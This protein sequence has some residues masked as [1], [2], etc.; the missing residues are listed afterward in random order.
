M[1]AQVNNREITIVVE[2]AERCNKIVVWGCFRGKG[3]KDFQ[4]Y[5]CT[6]ET[7]ME[8]YNRQLNKAID[9]YVSKCKMMGI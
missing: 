3:G 1:I 4:R 9:K 7:A 8:Y 2:K 5:F 6:L